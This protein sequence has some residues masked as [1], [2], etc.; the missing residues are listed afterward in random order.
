M[1]DL[2][3]RLKGEL[4]KKLPGKFLVV[5]GPD[6]GGK[7]TQLN[8]LQKS[9]ESAGLAVCRAV[10]P[11]GTDTGQRIRDILLH[12]KELSLSPMCETMLFMASRAQLV[13]EVVRPA[14]AAGQVVLCDRFISATLAYQ[15]ALG[16]DKK[17][18]VELGELATGHLWPDLTIILDVPVEVGMARVGK[19]RDRLESRSDEYHDKVRQAFSELA[20]DYPGPVVNV[21]AAASP[22]DVAVRILELLESCF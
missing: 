14:M 9:L 22:E 2:A 5:D 11:G 6:G 21:D 7:T 12:A 20:D 15:G 17:M 3:E 13:D 19:T 16:V 1:N 18:I 8:M 10:D 4:L